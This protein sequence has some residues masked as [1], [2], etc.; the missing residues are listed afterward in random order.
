VAEF[1]NQNISVVVEKAPGSKTKLHITVSP[2]AVKVAYAM[3]IK[4][5]NKEVSLP[6]FR[7]GKAPDSLVTQKFEKHVND[8]WHNIVLNTSFSEALILSKLTPLS[9]KAVGKPQVK[10]LSKEGAEF[11]ID[12]EAFPEVPTINPSDISL[13]KITPQSP[14]E[15][16]VED[17]IYDLRL[18]KAEW[19]TITDRGIQEGDFA[20][21]DIDS[22]EEEGFNICKDQ[23]FLVSKGKIGEWLYKLLIGKH[24]HD[25]VEGIS[26][27]DECKAC[28]DHTHDHHVHDDEPAFK[29]TRCK[30]TIKAIKKPNLPE[31]DEE[32][33]KK[34]GAE[35]IDL[36][37]ERVKGSLDN[38]L[39]EKAQQQL[40]REVEK[41]LA[42][43]Y[44]FEI[45][46]S[47]IKAQQASAVEHR[48]QLLSK[49]SD[50]KPV[51]SRKEVEEEIRK[52][53]EDAYRLYFIC[54]KI[55]KDYNIEVS[56]DEIMQEFMVQA[57]MT[58]QG[59]GY[60]DP[61]MNA[62]E[63]RSRVHTHLLNKKAGISPGNFERR[64]PAL[65]KSDDH[66]R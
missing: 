2:E 40:R 8:E 38:E 56:Q 20:D 6:G 65:R 43:K 11:T 31:L 7:K 36:L 4:N 33:A 27:K 5:I 62:E 41:K 44:P 15:E 61:Q 54:E 48:L 21:L 57:Y 66:F 52:E 26:E 25:V 29:P 39:K 37:K 24:T 30:V 59:E 42:E 64:T 34:I 12:F 63:I 47:L 49:K 3:A 58:R 1:K 32:F 50:G 22:L 16:D 14:T 46:H 45:P 55:A 13:K 17:R 28:D 18:N 35:N 19:G 53:L 60:I 51:P 10:S 9:E 23:G